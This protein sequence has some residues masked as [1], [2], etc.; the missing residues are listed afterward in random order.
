MLGAS[1]GLGALDLLWI[2]VAL[3]PEVVADSTVAPRPA[4]VT[5]ASIAVPVPVPLPE[6]PPV[7]VPPPRPTKTH[8][9]FATMSA[10]LDDAA[11]TILDDLV[12]DDAAFVLEGHAD[13]RG[14][15]RYNTKL[16][17]KRALAVEQ[18]LVE[19]GVGRDRVEVRYAGEAGAE[20]PDL[21]RDRRV[22]IL[23]TGGRP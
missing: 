9:Y 2:D 13:E 23:I 18:Y 21:W 15:D 16:S 10:D 7:V 4:P 22:D 3:A 14:N 6:P 12:T 1:L 20:D 17:R 11:R 19:R 8:V 5:V